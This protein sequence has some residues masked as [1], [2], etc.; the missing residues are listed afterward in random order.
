MAKAETDA[1]VHI[2]AILVRI[3]SACPDASRGQT[4]AIV[5]CHLGL[6]APRSTAAARSAVE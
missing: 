4:I 5:L 2:D 1:C 6:R 3:A